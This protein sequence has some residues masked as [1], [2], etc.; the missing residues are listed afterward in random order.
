MRTYKKIKLEND[1]VNYFRIEY[2]REF[3]Y[4]KELGNPTYKGVKGFLEAQ[5]LKI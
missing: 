1:L 3:N 4:H 2:P 5:G